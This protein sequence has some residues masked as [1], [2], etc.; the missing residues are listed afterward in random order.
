MAAAKT[1]GESYE[2]YLSRDWE[3]LLKDLD[4]PFA[5][6][7]FIYMEMSVDGKKYPQV[8][9][10]WK[11]VGWKSK[12]PGYAFGGNYGYWPKATAIKWLEEN[13][14]GWFPTKED[15]I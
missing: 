2:G 12:K 3:K 1:L 10:C 11:G 15:G 7:V 14:V 5:E 4:T 6:R 13:A 9:R 8:Y